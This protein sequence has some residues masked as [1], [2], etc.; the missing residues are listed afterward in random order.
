MGL[1]A[2]ILVFGMLRFKP[3][4]SLSSFT[5]IKRFFSSSSLSDPDLLACQCGAIATPG[6]LGLGSVCPAAH[7]AA[8]EHLLQ[9]SLRTKGLFPACCPQ[10][11]S[12]EEQPVLACPQFC[13]QCLCSWFP[14]GM[15]SHWLVAH[16]CPAHKLRGHC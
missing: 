2:T 1:D 9:H 15:T 6:G 16:N 4:F 5:F 14:W 13:L 7:D 10:G 12:R 8:R 3:A 11:S